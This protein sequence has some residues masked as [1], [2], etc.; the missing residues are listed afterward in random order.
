MTMKVG[1]ESLLK[2]AMRGDPR[3]IAARVAFSEIVAIVGALL[4]DDSES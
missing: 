2:S 4:D 3:I 1:I